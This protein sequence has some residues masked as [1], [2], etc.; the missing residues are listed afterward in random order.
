MVL[1]GTLMIPTIPLL[2]RALGMDETTAGMWAGGSIHEVAQVIAAGGAIGG[3]A[4]AV[5]AVVKLA[6][7]VMLARS[8]P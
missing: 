3:G 8:W 5:A 6:R 1:F 4:L 2:S 7:V